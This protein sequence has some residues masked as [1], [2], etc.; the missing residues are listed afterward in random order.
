MCQCLGVCET[1]SVSLWEDE[2][3]YEWVCGSMCRSVN[4]RVCEHVSVHK[5]VCVWVWVCEF[6]CVCGCE[7]LYP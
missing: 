3:V 5:G 2:G 1:D 4:K 6:V 7:S